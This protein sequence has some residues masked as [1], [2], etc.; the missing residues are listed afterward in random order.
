MLK[1]LK[2]K[3]FALIKEL[4]I[5]P[6]K[7]L[8]IITGETGAGKSIIINAISLLLGKRGDIKFIRNGEKKLVVE[9]EF[10]F[11][12]NTS[13]NNFLIAN[14]Y[15]EDEKELLIRREIYMNG[16]SRCFINDM[17]AKVSLLSELGAFL[18]DIHGQHDHQR[19]MQKENHL[20][21]LDKY[22]SHNLENYKKNFLTFKQMLKEYKNLITQKEE[23]S[24]RIS[25]IKYHLKEI[26]A[27]KPKENEDFEIDKELKKLE[28]V[29]E[30]KKSAEKINYISQAGK[31]SIL[32][33]IYD[34]KK[35]C[36]NF[37]AIEKDEFE[38][39]LEDLESAYISIKEFADSTSFFASNIDFNENKLNQLNSRYTELKKIMKKF[40]PEISDVLKYS[41]EIKKELEQGDNFDVLLTEKEKVLDILKQKLIKEAN[42]I[43]QLR[44]KKS[45]EFA[46]LIEKEFTVL[47]LKNS[48]IEVR[49]NDFLPKSE[50]LTING[51]DNCEFFICT[52]VG[53]DFKPL[54][55]TASGGE[56]SRI[57]LAIK[58]VIGAKSV[59]E[60]MIFD[61][62]DTG[63][64]GKTAEMTAKKLKLLSNERQLFIITHLPVIAAYATNHFYVSKKV[65]KE[66]TE[67]SIK[68][69]SDDERKFEIAKLIGG[70]Y[71]SENSLNNAEEL[72]KIG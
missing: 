65:V 51:F 6:C 33:G 39:Y 53:E 21:F 50:N 69:L 18:I 29:E 45:L 49:W 72:L 64:S 58:T 35:E 38:N 61:E 5:S 37:V 71:T 57:M 68:L 27:I 59:V 19:L 32:N 43:S 23:K 25:L 28:S 48:K 70:N 66:K 34:L 9:A 54:A 40:G 11:Q 14:E 36:A 15:F 20:D 46:T 26:D 8:N 60:T 2:I 30:L 55:K 56:I 1:S 63:I 47:G 24:N 31:N 41:Q 4:T 17:P 44:R 13:I 7:N 3:N 22:I 42:Q 10:E 62:I 16:K 67:S 52:N 12:E